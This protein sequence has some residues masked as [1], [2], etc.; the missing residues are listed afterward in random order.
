MLQHLS[1]SDKSARFDGGIEVTGSSL[2]VG[3]PTS[4]PTITALYGLSGSSAA[5]L[6]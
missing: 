3:L 6:N 2:L 4:E 5:H 1:N